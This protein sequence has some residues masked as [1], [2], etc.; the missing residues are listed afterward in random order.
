MKNCDQRLEFSLSTL[1]RRKFQPLNEPPFSRSACGERKHAR[2]A[3]AGVAARSGFRARAPAAAR[4]RMRP[5][6]IVIVGGGIGGLAAA[7]AMRREG[8]EPA[9]HERAPALLEVGARI[10]LRSEGRRGGKD[11]RSRW[12]PDH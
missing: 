9:G 6:R 12:S 8:F 1:L 4:A 5:M 3:S 10:A 7:L 11:G 2:A